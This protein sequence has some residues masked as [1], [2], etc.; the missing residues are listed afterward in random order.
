MVRYKPP[1]S[2][3]VMWEETG[4]GEQQLLEIKP[5]RNKTT[6]TKHAEQLLEFI[7]RNASYEIQKAVAISLMATTVT[8]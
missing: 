7:Q 4:R 2:V 1:H 3:L 5:P 6:F 8:M